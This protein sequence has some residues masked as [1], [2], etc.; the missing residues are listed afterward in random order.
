MRVL[1]PHT[2]LYNLGNVYLLDGLLGVTDGDI[3]RSVNEFP[4]LVSRGPGV[5]AAVGRVKWRGVLSIL[6]VLSREE[7]CS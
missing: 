7:V 2:F 4:H 6:V 1:T 3:V 5:L